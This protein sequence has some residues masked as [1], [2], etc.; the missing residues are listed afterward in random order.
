VA[1]END[2]YAISALEH[3]DVEEFYRRIRSRR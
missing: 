3:L 1:R 2:L